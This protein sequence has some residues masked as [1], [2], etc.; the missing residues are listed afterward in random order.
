MAKTQRNFS[1]MFSK[2]QLLNNIKSQ[3]L[4]RILHFMGFASRKIIAAFAVKKLRI[5]KKYFRSNNASIFSTTSALESG[6]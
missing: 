3:L 5:I 4:I 6:L 1:I 2:I